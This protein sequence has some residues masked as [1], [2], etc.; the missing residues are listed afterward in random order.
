MPYE[1]ERLGCRCPDLLKFLFDRV[2]SNNVGRTASCLNE[3]YNVVLKGNFVIE[4][5]TL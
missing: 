1:Y 2:F 3:F 4:V 5:K